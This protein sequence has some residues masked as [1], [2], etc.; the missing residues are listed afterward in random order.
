[1]LYNCW[2]MDLP[3]VNKR[4]KMCL[5]LKQKIMLKRIKKDYGN[6]I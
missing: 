3:F 4:A 2:K 6:M 5:T 1:M